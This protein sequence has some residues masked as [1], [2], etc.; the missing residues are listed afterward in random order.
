MRKVVLLM[1]SALSIGWPTLIVADEKAD[2]I[3][4]ARKEVQTLSMKLELY[5]R[6]NGAYPGSLAA[7]AERQ[8]GG[9]AAVVSVAVLKDPWGRTYEFDPKGPKNKGNQADVWSRG[10][11]GN[12]PRSVI[13]NWQQAARAKPEQAPPPKAAPEYPSTIRPVP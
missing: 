5:K 7:L 11:A 3:D 8:P 2:K 9:G 10:P 6:N 12:D 1:V 4:K 13:G